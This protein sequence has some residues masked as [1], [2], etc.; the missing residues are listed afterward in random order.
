MKSFGA[1]LQYLLNK[2]IVDGLLG[3][4]PLL[5]KAIKKYKKFQR[6]YGACG[7]E[8]GHFYSP[9][10]S[11]VEIEANKSRIFG[12][13]EVAGVD[14]NLPAQLDLLEKFKAVHAELPYD[15]RGGHE[16][17]KLRYRWLAGSQY[18]YSDVVFLYHTMRHLQP[19]RIIEIGSGFSSAVILDVNELFF[20]STIETTFI[21]PN[22][23][24]LF[25][26]LG[27]SERKRLSIVTEKVQSVPLD[28][29]Q[30]LEEN[31]ILFVDSSH[32]VKIGSDVNHIVFNILPNLRKGVCI[33]FHDVFFPFE[34]PMHWIFKYKRF[35]N[36]SYLLRAFLMNNDSYEIFLFNTFLQRNHRNWFEREMPECLIDEE[37]CGSIW[38]RKTR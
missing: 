26:L 32:V 35:W 3:N 28:A 27:E 15:F 6:A 1:D 7:S 8:P 21:E 29:F 11:L 22:P 24:R 12:Q 5:G 18:R 4:A 23:Q 10:P 38:I 13:T 31:D 9:I 19:K 2:Y 33:H 20:N 14:I 30:A 17:P 34:L 25:K 16:N 37:N 36:E